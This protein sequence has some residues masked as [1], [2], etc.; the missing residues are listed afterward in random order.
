MKIE[1]KD[2]MA[3]NVSFTLKDLTRL[4]VSKSQIWLGTTIYGTRVRIYTHLLIEPCL[5]LKNSSR[6]NGGMALEDASLGQVN[7]KECK[8]I[9]KRLKEIIG[10]CQDYADAVTKNTLHDEALEHSAE[11]FKTFIY[12]KI[13]GK[14]EKRQL[15]VEDYI[16]NYIQT[17]CSML[18][19][20]TKRQLS[21]GT[22]YNHRNSLRR[23]QQ[24]CKEKR[25]KLTWKLFDRKFET[26]FTEWLCSQSYSAN[27]IACQYSVM[28]VWLT[29]AE[30]DNL[31][32]DKAFHKYPTKVYN[33][34]NIYLTEEEIQRLYDIDFKSDEVQKE[35]GYQISKGGKYEQ[36]RDLFVLACW[37]GLRFHDWH[38]IMAVA[39]FTDDYMTVHTHK[40]N[41]EVIIPLHP[42]V[43]AIVKKY[44]GNL[45]RSGDKTACLKHIR[46]CGR[47]AHI[48]EATS[49]CRV[50]G[51]KS[52][53]NRGAKYEF[54][55]NH[56]ARRSF[57]TNMYLKG[58]PT[59]SVMAISGHTSEEN[60]LKY[61]KVD[62]KQH[63]DIVARAFK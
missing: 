17:K 40:T 25:I 18:N 6:G 43:K 7:L 53:I 55:C 44:D 9:N 54:I 8:A 26:K 3:M 14:D 46:E 41:K 13:D 19:K 62:R 20:D 56:T 47:I 61:I 35:L 37:T 45:P 31:I 59:I 21:K 23:L 57:C 27:T 28:K 5:W 22:I 34:E 36:S 29:E 52:V 15:D 49:L 10:F 48:D 60:F 32:T 12:A 63:A 2:K 39:D 1:I 11:N 51:G 24:F 33:V 42:M 4:G 30:T 50:R 16:G 38:N 58:V